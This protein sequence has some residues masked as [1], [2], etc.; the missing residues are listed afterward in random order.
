[1]DRNLEICCTVYN[2]Q[3]LGNILNNVQCTGTQKYTAHAQCPIDRNLEICWR[4]KYRNILNCVLRNMRI[5]K[6]IC[7]K[8]VRMYQSENHAI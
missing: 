3:K 5:G 2:G 6:Y 1:M 4:R 8:Q 7:N